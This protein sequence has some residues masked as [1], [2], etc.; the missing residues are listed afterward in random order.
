MS[1]ISAYIV[2]CSCG[3]VR[4]DGSA[5]VGRRTVVGREHF[6][7]ETFERTVTYDINVDFRCFACRRYFKVDQINASHLRSGGAR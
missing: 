6:R 1:R 4:V 2:K 3:R 7:G 5:V